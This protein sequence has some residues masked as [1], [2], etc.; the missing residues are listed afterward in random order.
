MTMLDYPLLLTPVYKDYLWGGNRFAALYSRTGTPAVA[1]ESWE[2]SDRPEGPSVVENGPL[3]GRTLQ[4]LLAADAPALL[5]PAA[6]GGKTF[7][8]LVKLIDA[9]QSLSVQVHPHDDN[10]A[11]CGGEPK[12]ECWYI[13]EAPPG[14]QVMAGF[15]PQASEARFRQALTEKKAAA[16]LQPLAVRKGDLI[17]IPGGRV[18][19]IGAGC[20]ILEVQQNSNTTYRLYDWDRVG[21]DGRPRELHVEQALRAIRWDDPTPS[22]T[23]RAAAQAVAPGV[24]VR[25][26]IAT[27]RFRLEHVA[28]GGAWALPEAAGFQAWF[29]AAGAL[30]L[31]GNGF[32][33]ECPHGRTC[34]IPAAARGITIAPA[35][36]AAQAVRITPGNQTVRRQAV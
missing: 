15:A 29:A 17:F 23:P 21:A 11:R 28:L 1:A 12:T 19:A 16:L 3:A 33:V 10:A 27:A 2:I 24:S 34:L 5:G 13:L 25:L 32:D 8:L 4:S 30:R 36:A 6:A 20:L 14:A 9:A 22:I 7:P 18:H 26:M 35:A 31:H